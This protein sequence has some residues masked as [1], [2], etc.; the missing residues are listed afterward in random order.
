MMGGDMTPEFSRPFRVDRLSAHP[1]N[2]SIEATAEERVRLASRLKLVALDHLSGDVRFSRDATTG[3]VRVQAR[4]VADVVQFCVV[5]L[6]AFPTH[7]EESFTVDFSDADDPAFTS[8]DGAEIIVDM[9]H[10]PPEPI[11]HGMI[12]M[13]E[14]IAQYL[15][16]ELD[17]YPRSPGVSLEE[18]WTDSDAPALSPFAVLEGLKLRN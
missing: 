15:S 14:L 9:D 4:F 2:E 16:L 11:E 10:E 7:V 17:P 13:G 3:L 8:A 1:V 6:E 18:V 5:T 12:D